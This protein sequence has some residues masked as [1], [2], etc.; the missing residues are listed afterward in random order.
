MILIKS[1]TSTGN[2][3]KQRDFQAQG[4]NV[5]Q[6]NRQIFIK[7]KY[8]LNTLNNTFYEAFSRDNSLLSATDFAGEDNTS[9]PDM[10]ITNV[11][12]SGIKTYR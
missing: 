3:L 7:T 9:F 1:V 6:K 11:C 10:P 2:I 5:L 12:C 4:L 8:I